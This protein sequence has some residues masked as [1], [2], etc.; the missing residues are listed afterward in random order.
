MWVRVTSSGELAASERGNDERSYWWPACVRKLSNPYLRPNTD[1]LIRTQV[2]EGRLT[3]GPLT[4]SLYGE[5]S[6]AAPS[7]VCIEAPSP[8]YILPFKKSGQDVTRFSS[9][10][11]K[12]PKAGLRLDS[13]SKRQK[14]ALDE[15]WRSA[16]DLAHEADAG[17]NDGLPSNLS[18]YKVGTARMY[19]HNKAEA[20]SPT[21]EAES[22]TDD[23]KD[24]SGLASINLNEAKAVSDMSYRAMVSP[25]L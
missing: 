21:D 9:V 25:S 15:A 6:P 10:T 7:N 19:E 12:C 5:I 1:P 4:V 8:S 24:S 22:S 13:P 3:T 17:L 2:T 23:T 14:T 11:F 20:E 18:S 16:V